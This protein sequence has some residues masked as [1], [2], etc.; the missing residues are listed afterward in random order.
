[1][2][3]PNPE[4]QNLSEPNDAVVRDLT[5]EEHPVPS[6]AGAARVYL[7]QEGDTLGD[8]ARRVYGDPNKFK[9][10][11]NANRDRLGEDDE[12]IPGS[13]LRIP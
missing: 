9:Q 5:G 1:M 13:E 8:I 3:K 6:G 2:P 7:V 11:L 12:P 4:D 10:I